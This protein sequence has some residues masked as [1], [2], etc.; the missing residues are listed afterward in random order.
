MS[1]NRTHPPSVLIVDDEEAICVLIKMKLELL[2]YAIRTA[3]SGDDALDILR[4]GCVDAVVTDQDLPGMKGTEFYKRATILQPHLRK[5]F[6]FITGN[7]VLGEADFP[8]R[9]LHKPFD[10]EVL[11]E[12][13]RELLVPA[14]HPQPAGC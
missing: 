14:K 7:T 12:A 2:G 9:L 10:L 5:R 1:T 11:G 6:L 13:V 3:M 4:E 8:S